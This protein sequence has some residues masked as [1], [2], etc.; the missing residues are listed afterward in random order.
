MNLRI[1]FFRRI[2][3]LFQG[4]ELSVSKLSS[5][6]STNEVSEQLPVSEVGSSEGG[7]QRGVELVSS[8]EIDLVG[9]EEVDTASHRDTK[10]Q[11]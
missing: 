7:W 6:M 1:F 3:F 11:N 8:V 9:S 2:S 5:K 4:Q 10:D